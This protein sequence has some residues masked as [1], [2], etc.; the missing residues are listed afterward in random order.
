VRHVRLDEMSRSQGRAQGQFAGE[1]TGTD[2][3]CELARVVAGVRG[4]G[5]AHAQEI[6]HRGLGLEDGAA[7]QGA[8]F[9]GRHGDGDLEVSAKTG[10][11]SLAQMFI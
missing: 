5:A 3:A 11:V 8:D 9:D 6:E 2:D 4:V 7:A 1:D 10:I